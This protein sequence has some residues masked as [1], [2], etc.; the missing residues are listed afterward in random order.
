[1]ET[2]GFDEKGSVLA[3]YSD[4]GSAGLE[5]DVVI[6]FRVEIGFWG[7]RGIGSDE[8]Q[9]LFF[10]GIPYELFELVDEFHNGPGLFGGP[11]VWQL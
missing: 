9:E 3:L 6:E 8:I 1:L 5:W 10:I 2:K 7:F 4:R 11:I